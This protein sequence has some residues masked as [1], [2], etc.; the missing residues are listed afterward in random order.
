LDFSPRLGFAFRPFNDNKT[1]IRGGYGI[2][3]ASETAQYTT[4]GSWVLPFSGT[5]DYFSKAFNW[6]VSQGFDGQDHFVT[7]DKEPYNLTAKLGSTPGI[8]YSTDPY[9]PS[10][11]FQQWNLTLAREVG[12]GVA[13]ETAYVGSKGTNLNGVSSF[14]A[15]RPALDALAKKNVPGWGTL[16]L[17]TKGYNSKFNA[18][19]VKATKRLSRGLEFLAAFT[20]G[21]ALAESSNEDINEN[22]DVDL[23]ESGILTPTRKW[24]NGD[25]DVRKRFTFSG[26][27][28]LPIGRGRS[29]GR[30][31]NALTDSL[32]GGWR[33]NY[34]L[35]LQ[36]GRPWGVR[37]ASN[38]I[39]DR[40][41]D[42][43]LPTSERTADRWFDTAC[44]VPHA[45]RPFTDPVTGVTRTIDTVGNAGANIIE[46]PGIQSLDLGIHKEFAFTET[47]NL[48]LRFE[49]FNVLNHPNFI[50]PAGNTFTATPTGGRLTRAFD[51]R[52][53]QVAIKFH[54]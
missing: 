2:F 27:Y 45:G 1:A 14:P 20:W 41:C 48:Q 37:T 8:F 54:F 5:F 26:S 30:E 51:N 53:I 22:T 19:E 39:P 11:Y 46:G 23:A 47:A 13:L 12:W 49:A 44:F 15:Y 40:I 6:P 28:Q 18:L 34:I 29:L 24:S 32:L 16:G 43:N 10:A 36:D 25:F 7:I 17:W 50:G 38:T 9:F 3:Y 52:D 35:R 33:M 21:H 31:W 42:G 4:Y